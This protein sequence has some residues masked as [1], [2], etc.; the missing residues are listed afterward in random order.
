MTGFL[1][2]SG[3]KSKYLLLLILC[4]FLMVWQRSQQQVYSGKE[5]AVSNFFQK[6]QVESFED[7]E[8]LKEQFF[9]EWQDIDNW[10]GY[11]GKIENDLIRQKLEGTEGLE[12]VESPKV[13]LDMVEWRI[14]Q[15]DAK[16]KWTD[17]W[18]DDEML[19]YKLCEEM[20]TQFIWK[21]TAENQLEFLSRNARRY[22]GDEFRKASFEKML[23]HYQV[24]Y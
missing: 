9:K 6:E 14:A 3:K 18:L 11:P 1:I 5:T 8:G 23:Q 2:K 4:F 16:G 17:T 13:T 15:Y 20:K 22:R 7:L 12:G 21:E 19:V 24:V 10:V